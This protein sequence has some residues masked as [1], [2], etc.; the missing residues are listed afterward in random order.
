V[1][2]GHKEM[3]GGHGKP[4]EGSKRQCSHKSVAYSHTMLPIEPHASRSQVGEVVGMPTLLLPRPP[5]DTRRDLA[6]LHPSFCMMHMWD[7]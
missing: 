4:F 7:G 2:V 6:W 3:L 5:K 1:L